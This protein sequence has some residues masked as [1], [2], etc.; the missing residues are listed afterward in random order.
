MGYGDRF[1]GE[2]IIEPGA[3]HDRLD[4]RDFP[5]IRLTQS[6]TQGSR[7]MSFAL[8]EKP[9]VCPDCGNPFAVTVSEQL[10]YAE[11]GSRLPARCPEC[12]ANRRTERH[13]EAIR[14]CESAPA[15]SATD[16]YGGFSGFATSAGASRGRNARPASPPMF[17]AVCTACGASA[18]VPFEPRD[19]RPVYCR[20]CFN[21]RRG[22]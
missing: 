15:S 21:A 11:R 14:A 13:A 12:R 6:N 8:A 20:N 1:N 19:R 18:S 7:S 4:R 16:G 17:T 10:F 2:T 9:L 3:S 5:L 22:K